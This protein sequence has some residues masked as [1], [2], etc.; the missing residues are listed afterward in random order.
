MEKVAA[1]HG[2]T[3]AQ[4]ALAW[5]LA[6]G[7]HVVPVP[8]TKQPR[9]LADNLAAAELRLTERDVRDLDT[10]PAATGSRY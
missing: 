1:R 5:T 2:A 10:A 4:V 9:Y 6:Q 8:G 3:A 7:D